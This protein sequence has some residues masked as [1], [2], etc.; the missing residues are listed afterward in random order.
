MRY[1]NGECWVLSGTATDETSLSHLA[2]SI[3]ISCANTSNMSC[4]SKSSPQ[5]VEPHLTQYRC[6]IAC[7]YLLPYPSFCY[8]PGISTPLLGKRLLTFSVLYTLSRSNSLFSLC[9][10]V[11]VSSRQGS[12]SSQQAVTQVISRLRTFLLYCLRP[13][14]SP[15]RSMR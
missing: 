11:V 6:R 5:T 1:S 14:G 12:C 3:S 4:P 9:S 2:T 8:E 7:Y 13:R 15:Y 10:C